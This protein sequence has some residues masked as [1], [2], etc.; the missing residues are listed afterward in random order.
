[1]I[2]S[3]NFKVFEHRYLDE[4]LEYERNQLVNA[5]SIEEAE[6][7]LADY[8]KCGDEEYRVYYSITINYIL[9]MLL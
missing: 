8:W 5:D 3:V 9:P 1:M 2:Y 7:K 4:C 6:K